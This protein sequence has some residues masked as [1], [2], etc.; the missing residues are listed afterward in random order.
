[1]LGNLWREVLHFPHV[2]RTSVADL[3]VCRLQ[4]YGFIDSFTNSLNPTIEGL[5]NKIKRW[6]NTEVACSLGPT[7]AMKGKSHALFTA[8]PG[9][10]A[11]ARA[12]PAGVLVR[13]PGGRARAQ[14]PARR[15]HGPLEYPPLLPQ[16]SCAVRSLDSRPQGRRRRGQ[17]S[18][19]L[20]S[21]RVRHSSRR[22]A[23]IQ[24]HAIITHT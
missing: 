5:Q 16:P 18:S 10:R 11:R 19:S 3:H 1:M 17:R 6:I 12:R 2:L 9:G 24:G 14:A 21:R 4:A 7:D 15:P 23:E 20:P 8:R 13:P 22:F